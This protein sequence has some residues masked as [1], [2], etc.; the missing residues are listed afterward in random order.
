MRYKVIISI[1]DENFKEEKKEFLIDSDRLFLNAKISVVKDLG[2]AGM[3]NKMGIDC[4]GEMVITSCLGTDK[5]EINLEEYKI[6]NL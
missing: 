6:D 3:F 1:C 5:K 4:S 2:F